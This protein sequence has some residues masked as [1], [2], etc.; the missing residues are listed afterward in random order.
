MNNKTH[1][2]KI[3]AQH[4]LCEIPACPQPTAL[5]TWYKAFT[6]WVFSKGIYVVPFELIQKGHGQ[7]NAFEF[8]FGLPSSKSAENAFTGNKAFFWHYTNHMSSQ[9]NLHMNKLQMQVTMVTTVYTQSFNKSILLT[10]NAI[11]SSTGIPM[12]KKT[13]KTSSCSMRNLKTLLTFT[14]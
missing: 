10:R 12:P 8:G 3:T 14:V 11:Q 5:H 7:G 9:K 1:I 6:Q 2:P 13:T 4:I